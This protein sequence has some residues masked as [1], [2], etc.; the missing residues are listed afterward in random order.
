ML[1]VN[2]FLPTV[3]SVLYFP[4]VGQIQHSAIKYGNKM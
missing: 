4:E 1:V 3:P 2:L